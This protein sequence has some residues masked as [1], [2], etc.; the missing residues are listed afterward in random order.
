MNI[1]L[2]N[3]LKKLR[4]N[5]LAENVDEFAI[6][7][8]KSKIAPK[9]IIEKIVQLELLEKS[10]RSTQTRLKQAKLN[11]FKNIA[12]YDWSFPKQINRE[13]VESLIK[14]EFIQKKENLIIAGTQGLG[15]SM[16]AKNIAYQAVLKGHKVLFVTAS[17]LVLDLNTKRENHIEFKR[18]IKRF[19]T[20]DLLIIDELGYLSYDCQAADVIFEIINRRYEI[21][22]IIITTNLPFKEWG[23]IFPGANCLSAMIDRL[24]HH[25]Q[26]LTIK[27][28]SY[29]LAESQKG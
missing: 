8:T 25:L 5:Y 22:S 21:G 12:E 18:A 16:I 10:A 3:D 19:T 20:P 7:C 26:I 13:L 15:K 14:C 27:G 24:T 28:P 17:Q 9:E 1:T 11:K 6:G 29:R 23:T 2:S 4:L